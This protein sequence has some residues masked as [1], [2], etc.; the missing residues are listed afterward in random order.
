MPVTSDLPTAREQLLLELANRLRLDPAGE[1]DALIADAATGTAVQGNITSAL[2]WFGVDPGALR[3]QMAAYGPVAPLAWNGA[4]AQAAES[5]TQAMIAADSQ[6]HQLPGEASLGARISAAGYANWSSLS[7]NIY[8]YAEDPLHAHAGFVIDWGYDD[9]D[10]AG[11]TLRSDWQRTGDGIQDAAGH[12]AGLLRA[13]TTEAGFAML[14]ETDPATGVG[15]FLVTQDFGTRWDYAPQLVGVVIADADGDAFYDIGEGLAGVT[16]TASGAAGSFATTS[17]GSGGYQMVLPPGSYVVSFEGG[18]IVG[19]VTHAVSIGAANVKQDA[20]ASEAVVAGDLTLTGTAGA[21]RLTGL[22]GN[23]TVHGDG[24]HADHALPQA[25]QVW[26]LYRAMLDRAPD[27]AGQADWTARLASGDETL[28]DVARG[29][30]GSREFQTAYGALD[31][32]GF[33]TL[34]YHNVLDRDPDAAGLASWTARLAGGTARAEVALGFSES[35]EFV[36][37]TGAEATGFTLARNPATWTDEVYR[38]Y[39]ATLDRDPDATGFADWLDRL[40]DGTA[41]ATAVTGFIGSREFRATYG[42]LD[43]AGFVTLLYRNVLDRAPD[44]LGLA[45]W[46]DRLAGGTARADIVLGFAESREFVSATAAGLKTFVRSLGPQDEIRGGG[47]SN[48]LWGGQLA[49]TFVFGT[50]AAAHRVMDLEAWDLLSFQGFG[51]AGAGDIRA[52]MAQTGADVVFHDRGVGVTLV[53]TELAALADDM[54]G[55]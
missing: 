49:D 33:V 21:D 28:A 13:G 43:D 10:F 34:L 26:R 46:L 7:E 4:L 17:W 36:T 45:G 47:G 48:L 12:R 50:E 20:L 1:F 2:R 5:H 54:L 27:T 22:G 14:A 15:P 8:A 16:V 39:R 25:L 6:S 18:G 41:L 35:R 42:T 40:G 23:D 11:G 37:R 32:A 29:F 19:R 55:F 3:S 30:A 9:A 53:Q 51:Y 24:F 31:D 38:L 44:A 52:H